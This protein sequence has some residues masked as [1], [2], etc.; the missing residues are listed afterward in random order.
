V[1]AGLR[2]LAFAALLGL[3]PAQADTPPRPAD[4]GEE[5]EDPFYAYDDFAWR[6]FLALNAP[7]RAEAGPRVWERYASRD[8]LAAS[9]DDNPCG[10]PAGEKV[11]S[12]FTPYAEFNQTTFTPGEPDSPLV[13]RSGTYVRYETRFG[14][15]DA[16]PA[17]APWL[18]PVGAV[19]IKAAWRV[20]TDADTQAMRDRYYVAHGWITD[21]A[22]SR[23]AGRVVCGQADLALVGLH[24]VVRTPKA[25]QGI[26]AS[27]E[28]VDNVPPAG[29]GDAREPDARDEGFA[30][31]FNDPKRPQREI[32]PP[33]GWRAAAPV[34][35]DNPPSLT[36]APSQ[37]LRQH[38]IRHEIMQA[39]RAFWAL[40]EVAGSV[41]RRYML[42][43]VQW[44]TV[45]SPRGPQNDG[46]YFPGLPPEPDS[47]AAK[48]KVEEIDDGRNGANS[49]METYR[50]DAPATCMAC[51]HAVANVRGYDFVGALGSAASRN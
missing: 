16:P 45:A 23:A 6:T 10:A 36:P 2:W 37:V 15:F 38:P 18:A 24:V 11:V 19:A 26:W 1:S 47:K 39:N 40:P 3:A 51:H 43:A 48:Y 5:G 50:Q 41:W 12:A 35:A 29:L 49:V 34:T 13:A 20:L 9:R 27:F 22:A 4:V 32:W 28:H 44:P 21:V 17:S 7:A 30:F 14:G 46:R 33:Q 31:A 25:P 8:A 42:V